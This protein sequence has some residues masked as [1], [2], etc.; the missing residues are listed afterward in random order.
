MNSIA[1]QHVRSLVRERT[2]LVLVALLFGITL[3][4]S[5]IGWSSHRTVTSV[6]DQTVIALRASGKT[7]PP[8][9]FGNQPGLSILKNMV[10]Y[11]PL[12][13]SLLAIIVGQMSVAGDHLAGVMK[14]IF[15]RPVSRGRYLSGKILGIAYVLSGIIAVCFGTSLFSMLVVNH[16][17]PSIFEIF[18][19]SLFYG[20]S[21]LY[22]MLFALIGLSAALMTRSQS[23]SLL[24]SIGVWIVISFVVPQF[25]SGV[26]PIA[27]L[28]PVSAPIGTSQTALFRA[29]QVI[30]PFSLNERFKDVGIQW[31]DAIPKTEQ[32]SV[33]PQVLPL[34]AALIGVFA[35]CWR[36]MKRIHVYEDSIND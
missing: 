1:L 15:S 4:S 9:P 23:L 14:L 19:L 7:I 24:G 21:F 2:V 33:A 34:G 10:I 16:H 25:A 31:L 27:S 26:S 36:K 28:N 18:K 3:A 30:R 17:T 32:T 13:G 6:Y 11:I 20:L 8:N 22:L 12:V 29:T 5:F 35:F